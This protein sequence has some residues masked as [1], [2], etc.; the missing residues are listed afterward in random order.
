MVLSMLVVAPARAAGAEVGGPTG[1]DAVTLCGGDDSFDAFWPPLSA[2]YFGQVWVPS[3][4]TVGLTLSGVASPSR[5]QF[6]GWTFTDQQDLWLFEH[7]AQTKVPDISGAPMQPWR[8]I[9]DF[10]DG[11]PNGN[12]L[13]WGPFGPYEWTNHGA[14]RSIVIKSEPYTGQL[15]G[16]GGDSNEW[17]V[18]VEV[19]DGTGEIV[20][21]D[22]PLC[23]PTALPDSEAF[24]PNATMPG[25]CPCNGGTHGSVN[26]RTGN[27]HFRLP[28]V[29][30]PGRG[31]ALDFRLAY[32]SLDA[33]YDGPIG[34]GWRHSYDMQLVDNPDGSKTVVQETGAHVNFFPDGSGGWSVAGRM[35]ASLTS[36]SGSDLVFQRG[37]FEFFTFDSAGRLVEIA[38]RNGYSTTL[39]YDGTGDLDFVEDEA[40]RRLDFS[41]TGGRVSSISDPRTES[42]GTRTIGFD[43]DANGDLVS[44]DDI[45]GG[46]WVMGYDSSH[47]LTSARPP[48]FSDPADAYEFHYD[49]EGRVDWEEDPLDRRTWLYYDDPAPGATRI[50]NPDGDA[51]VDWYNEL[52]Q[53]VKVTNGYGTAAATEVEFVYDPVTFMV[54]KMID[55]N[56]NEWDYA[57]GDP[58]NPHSRTSATDPLGRVTQTS[59]N[60]FGQPLT[61]TDNA[62]V[63]AEMTYDASGNPLTTTMAN[64]TAVEAVTTFVYGDASHPEDVTSVID[65]RSHAWLNSYDASTG[66]LLDASDPEG[67]QTTW[68]YNSVGWVDHTTAPKGNLSGAI[69]EEYRTHFTYNDYG[70]PLTVTNTADEVVTR[71]YDANRN[72]KTVTDPDNETTTFAYDDADQVVEVQR[73]DTTTVEYGY[74]ADGLLE[75][76][77]SATGGVWSSTYDSLGRLFTATDPNN[78][79]TSYAWDA[80]GNQIAM[81][82]PGGDCA[83]SPKTGCVTY[84]YDD[85]N[86]LMSVDYSDPETAD[87][88]SVS[89]DEVGRRE[90][91]TLGTTPSTTQNW[92]WNARGEL[93]SYTDSSGHVTGYDWDP[94]GNLATIVYPGE[95]LPVSYGYDE[96]GRMTSVTDWLGNTTSFTPDPHGNYDTV[97]F[98]A[99][100]GNVDEFNFDR[101]DRMIGA[102]WNQDAT[103]LGSIDWDPRDPEGLVAAADTTGLPGAD[104]TY[105]YDA[106]DRLTGM[107]TETAAYDA[108]GDL[109]Q[110]LD[111]ATQTFDPAQQLCWASPVGA[112]GTCTT[113]PVDATAFDYDDRGNRTLE[114]APGGDA[115]FAYDQASRLSKAQVDDRTG[116]QFQ[117]V[118]PAAVMNTTPYFKTGKC[119]TATSQCTTLTT[120]NNGR[121]LSVQVSGEGGLPAAEEI[122]AVMVNVTVTGACASCP[123]GQLV[124]YPSDISWPWTVTSEF[125]GDDSVSNNII[126]RLG[127]DGRLNVIT[128][129][130]AN[131]QIDVTGYFTANDGTGTDN[132]FQAVDPTGIAQT[133]PDYPANGFG[134]CQPSCTTPGGGSDLVRDFMVLGQGGVPDDPAV[135]AVAVNVSTLNASG[136]GALLLG[137]TGASSSVHL[138]YN[139]GQMDSNMAIVPVGTDGRISTLSYGPP[140]DIRIDVY[141]YFTGDPDQA[142]GYHPVQY[143]GVLMRAKAGTTSIGLCPDTTTQCQPIDA[144]GTKAIT[145]QVTGLAG[146]PEHD[147]DAVVVNITAE[148]STDGFLV[149][150]ADGSSALNAALLYNANEQTAASATIPVSED[151]RIEIVAPF[152]VA[153]VDVKLD[154][155]GYFS[156]SNTVDYTYDGD[157]LRTS[158]SSSHTGTTTYSYSQAGGLPLL[159]TETTDEG[160]THLIYGPGGMPIAQI[161]PDDTVAYYHHD[162]LGSTRLVTDQAGNPLGTYTYDPYG[163]LAESTG[164]FDPLLDFAGQYTDNETGHQYLR[165]RY[166]DPE[167]GQFLTRDPLVATTM[168]PYGY[169]ANNPINN[170]DPSGLCNLSDFGKGAGPLPGSFCGDGSDPNVVVEDTPGG[171]ATSVWTQVG[172]VTGYNDVEFLAGEGHRIRLEIRSRGSIA[173]G[174]FVAEKHGRSGG[175][176]RGAFTAR[177]P[178]R[179]T[180]QGHFGGQG[181]YSVSVG[182]PPMVR[183][184]CLSANSIFCIFEAWPVFQVDVYALTYFGTRRDDC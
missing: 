137:A 158:K 88:T 91:L 71:T 162:Q 116:N 180:F 30:I 123:D 49:A 50:V 133:A 95:T 166:Y 32:N 76:W 3:G 99:A 173:A 93:T 59:Y 141:G 29:A 114:S 169:A 36:G 14:S 153:D 128:T 74:F 1:E 89:Y 67:N 7:D 86:Q 58:V 84:A 164:T 2:D 110:R 85:A 97:T 108:A 20:G 26:S 159:L 60:A 78:L 37:D 25:D 130:D 182:L 96:A 28:G 23:V 148:S 112:T 179:A 73:P 140:V 66:Y 134:D 119:P 40:S 156:T 111:G 16:R 170:T 160:P 171:Q 168:E 150:R 83:A 17:T 79:T 105:T 127:D 68:S 22:G 47:R 45:G 124:V 56:D 104:E 101:A 167:T 106:L 62:G 146:I 131:V 57:Y 5:I 161:N 52:G 80:N 9:V 8:I 120:A 125:P 174:S 121:A 10:G 132:A 51:R 4:A 35:H 87:I 118:T 181:H 64:G 142:G 149:T 155:H 46:S 33:S 72:V 165:A 6:R 163:A 144:Q 143:P 129:Q 15:N 102:Q 63:V 176:A 24:G 135:T 53:R 113:P 21:D 147:V 94:S 19:K 100:T 44:Y 48:R 11:L 39:T 145:V 61:M 117:A 126:T 65:A 103:V 92:V 70:D 107:N 183:D 175:T 152:A 34:H 172:S 139:A 122:E 178:G 98:P 41:W 90:V 138:A 54:T 81:Q 184:A 75:S 38:D 157:G 69:P 42:P 82:Q 77:T 136:D 43:Y 18:D 27:E 154:I 151:G 109:T 55:G 13:P 115:V 177:N 12:D 31:P